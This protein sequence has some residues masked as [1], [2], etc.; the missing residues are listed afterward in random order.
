MPFYRAGGLCFVGVWD[1]GAQ[2]TKELYKSP[3]IVDYGRIADCTFGRRRGGKGWKWW[4]WWSDDDDWDGD[5]EFGSA[6]D[7]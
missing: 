1:R 7:L 6:G 3:S 2:M 4:S 5:H